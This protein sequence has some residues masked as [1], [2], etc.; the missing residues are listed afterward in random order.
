MLGRQDQH[1]RIMI[2]GAYHMYM[3]MVRDRD[4]EQGQALMGRLAEPH[5]QVAHV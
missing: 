5:T 1:R 2:G 4:W 3:G